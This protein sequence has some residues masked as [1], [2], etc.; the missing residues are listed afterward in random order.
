M[1]KDRTRA[2]FKATVVGS[3]K[4]KS[5]AIQVGLSNRLCEAHTII[6]EIV[7]TIELAKE[8]VAN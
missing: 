4:K 7:H 1:E 2:L 3:Q 6:A 5:R 8:H